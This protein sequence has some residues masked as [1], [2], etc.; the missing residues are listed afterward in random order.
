MASFAEF[1]VAVAHDP[2]GLNYQGPDRGPQYRSD[3]FF[4]G[5]AQ[6]SLKRLFPAAYGATPVWSGV[7]RRARNQADGADH[8]GWSALR[9]PQTRAFAAQA[10]AV[11]LRGPSERPAR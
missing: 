4:T 11:M 2:T 5:P 8:N 6:L 10:V 9:R 1:F 3:I 7:P